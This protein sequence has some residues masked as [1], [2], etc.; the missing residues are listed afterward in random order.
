MTKW[1]LSN[2]S[3]FRECH[4]IF[5]LRRDRE[6]YI[7]REEYNCFGKIKKIFSK[8]YPSRSL[9][10]TVP[11]KKICHPNCIILLAHEVMSLLITNNGQNLDLSRYMIIH[12]AEFLAWSHNKHQARPRE[13]SWAR[14]H[15]GEAGRMQLFCFEGWGDRS[16][17]R[18]VCQMDVSRAVLINTR[19]REL[20]LAHF[21]YF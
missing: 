4:Y 6:S 9:L 1:F 16:R 17:V 10:L 13:I 8:V 3:I 5:R 12:T 7:P 19:V 2:F 18:E 21:I 20:L 15:C 14:D 11:D